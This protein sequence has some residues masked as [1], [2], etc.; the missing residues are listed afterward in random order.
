MTPLNILLSVA[1]DTLPTSLIPCHNFA[2]WLM[3]MI[4]RIL[5]FIGL[6]HNDLIEEIAYTA[7]VVAVAI[8]IGIVLRK[9]ALF[10][11]RKIVRLRHKDQL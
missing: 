11:A 10:I 7:V 5:D 2:V 9:I 4:R 1:T 8:F 3:R 6:R